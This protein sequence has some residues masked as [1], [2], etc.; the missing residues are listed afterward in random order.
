MLALL[1][2]RFVHE[3]D[4]VTLSYL[5]PSCL[6]ALQE[7]NHHAVPKLN[8]EGCEVGFYCCLY[9]LNAPYYYTVII[10]LL[11]PLHV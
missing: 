5:L 4:F 6:K 9:S 1:A 11:S 7:G 2:S 8:S 10:T 3:H